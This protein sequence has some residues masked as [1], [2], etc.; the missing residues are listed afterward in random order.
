MKSKS[1]VV[2]MLM[3]M[4]VFTI[5]MA[6]QD[7]AAAKSVYTSKCSICHGPD[8]HGNTSIGK[9]LKIKDFHS[10]DV[11]QMSDAD[12]KL[13]ITNGKNKMPQFKGKLTEAQIDQVIAY[14][15]QLGK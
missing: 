9:N 6:A 15:R 3:L 2:L 11:Q 4:F 5:S 8:G 13:I 7:M 14:V 1:V 10:P 12:L